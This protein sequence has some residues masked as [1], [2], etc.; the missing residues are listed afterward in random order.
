ML[1]DPS[2]DLVVLDELTYMLAY[3]YLDPQEVIAA[4][5]NRPPQQNVI[6][7]TAA[8]MPACWSLPIRSA[9]C[10]R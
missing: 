4:I 3:R 1:V 6:V 8:A 5:V 7:T 10:A 2:Y 9:S